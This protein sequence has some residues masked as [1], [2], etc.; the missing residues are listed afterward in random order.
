MKALI[1]EDEPHAA[2]RLQKYVNEIDKNIEFLAVL[3]SID[4][5]VAWFSEQPAPDLVFMDIHLSDGNCFEIF[6]RVEV[7]SP[8]IFATAYDEYALRAFEQHSI[9]YILK[10]IKKKDLE[11]ALAKLDK[12]RT[13]PDDLDRS[14]GITDEDDAPNGI[15]RFLIKVGPKINLIRL[16]DIAYFYSK[17]KI[18]F[19]ITKKGRRFPL[20]KS[21]EVLEQEV[22]DQEFFR[23][24]RKFIIHMDSI[25]SMN[26]HTKGRVKIDLEPKAELESIVSTERSPHF[27]KWLLS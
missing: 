4:S 16:D 8:I 1:I 2:S 19:A 3:E 23:I 17:D 18:T 11:R 6:D 20:N 21:L 9:D 12:Y 27:K 24:N 13:A 14:S 10:P 22:P 5:A 26:S 25:A 15:R 7:P